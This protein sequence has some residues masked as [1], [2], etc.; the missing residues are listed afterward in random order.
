M[1]NIQNMFTII[2]GN[3]ATRLLYCAG[4]TP[5]PGIPLPGNCIHLKILSQTW[6][7]LMSKNQNFKINSSRSL[8][9][10]INRIL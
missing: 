9:I 6:W 3:I 7:I 1:T 8:I 4:T 10:I 2:N 5:C